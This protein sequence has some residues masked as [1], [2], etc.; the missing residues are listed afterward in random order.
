MSINRGSAAGDQRV[1]ATQRGL[2]ERL[3]GRG[4]LAILA[5]LP[6]LAL[7]ASLL[8]YTCYQY[9]FWTLLN[10]VPKC[11]TQFAVGPVVQSITFGW[12]D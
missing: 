9:F 7:F 4:G 10:R 11:L 1:T 8:S 6:A 2:V 12:R 5:Y 3:G